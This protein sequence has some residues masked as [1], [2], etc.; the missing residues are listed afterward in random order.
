MSPKKI[1]IQ[2]T[3]TLFLLLF[4][5][6]IAKKK[7]P[8]VAEDLPAISNSTTWRAPPFKLPPI[9][10]VRTLSTLLIRTNKGDLL[11][12]LFSD[13]AP[14][15]VANLK[16]LSDRGYYKNIKFHLYLDEYVLQTGDRSGT[17]KG[18]VSYALP[19]EFSDLE[20]DFGSLVMARRSDIFNPDR[21]SHGSQFQII[22]RPAP[23]M[24]GSY[25]VFG[26]LLRGENVL[27]QL[28]K[29]DLIK[30]LTVFVR[31]NP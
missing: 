22:L 8:C 3:I 18:G 26:K 20:I 5:L 29:G 6:L 21:S 13:L 10:E 11:F 25:T 15:H 1:Q 16:Y 31:N 4:I 27:R 12:K 19:A 28:R 9:E 2:S 7:L 23:H 30:E 14:W 24:V 17:G